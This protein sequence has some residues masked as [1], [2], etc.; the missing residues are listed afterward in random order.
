MTRNR[1]RE[2]AGLGHADPL[3]V[4]PHRGRSATPAAWKG[5][6]QAPLRLAAREEALPVMLH[7]RPRTS[8]LQAQ[9]SGM[10]STSAAVRRFD[11]QRYPDRVTRAAA[12][13]GLPE[14]RR[15]SRAPLPR[16][17]G[18]AESVFGESP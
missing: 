10:R 7:R 4:N 1:W 5:F 6:P 14:R 17:V 9:V 12:V 13:T 3:V 2:G 15:E 16:A 11:R 8:P 18:G